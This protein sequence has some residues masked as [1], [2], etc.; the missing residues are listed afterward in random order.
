[1]SSRRSGYFPR[2][3]EILQHGRISVR[4]IV[5]ATALTEKSVRRMINNSDPSRFSSVEK[6]GEFLRSRDIPIDIRHEFAEQE[7]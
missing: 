1:M 4:E 3:R 6:V 7:G 2:L 5:A